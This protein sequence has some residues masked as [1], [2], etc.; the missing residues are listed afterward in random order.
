MR[1]SP[2]LIGLVT[3]FVSLSLT[4]YLTYQ[5]RVIALTREREELNYELHAVHD[6]FRTLLNHNTSIAYAIG[7]IYEKYGAPEDFYSLAAHLM[8]NSKFVDGIQLSKGG[9]MTHAYPY[10]ANKVVIGFD[11]F[12]DPL[13][14]KEAL[15]TI[16]RK[17]IHFAGPYD[18]L[19]GGGKAIIGRL[20]VFRNNHFIGFSVVLTKLST[21]NRYINT[22]D[23]G[24]SKFIY[25]LSKKHPIHNRIEYFYY[26]SGFMQQREWV[27]TFIKEGDWT[28]YVAH[29]DTY[30]S[31]LSGY[32][33]I[34]FLGLILSITFGGFAYQRARRPEILNAI[35]EEKSKQLV[36]DEQYYRTIIETSSDA[37]V[38]LNER[39]QV[40]YQTPSTQRISGYSLH[41]FQKLDGLELIHPDD[42]ELAKSF[43]GEALRTPGKPVHLKH[44]LRHKKGYY[45]WLEGTYRN[46]L[47]DEY[48]KRLVMTYTDVTQRVDFENR[49][50]K[51]NR[52][53]TLL[54]Q[55][56]D[57]IYRYTNEAELLNEICKCAVINGGYKLA[58]ISN[59][60]D[61]QDQH[62]LI[63]TIASYGE[64]DYLKKVVISTNDPVLKKGPT[65]QVLLHGKPVITN[66]VNHSDNFK[67]WLENARQF[68]IAASIVMP[69]KFNSD[70]ISG[71]LNIYSGSID[72]FDANEAETLE[73]VANNLSLAVRNIRNR[74]EK[75]EAQY[76]LKERIKELTAI[77]LVNK[78]IHDDH[79]SIDE[80]LQQVINIL[81]LGWQYPEVCQARI[82]YGE[83]V[84]ETKNYQTP[85]A[86]QRSNFR[87]RDDVDGSLEVSYTVDRPAFDEGPFL[88]EE[89]ELINNLAE[90][91]EDSFNKRFNQEA[92]LKSEANLQSVFDNT[93]IGYALL[94][95]DFIILAFNKRI[96]QGYAQETGIH[97][98]LQ[99][100]FLDLLIQERKENTQRM[101]EE[102]LLTQKPMEY[103]THF[104]KNNTTHYYHITLIPVINNGESI[105]ICLSAYDIT[106]AK[107]LEL[108]RKK[109]IQ[110]IIQR[111]RDLEQ[112][113]YI[114]A[115][116]V[117]APLATIL[118]LSSLLHMDLGEEDKITTIHGIAESAQRLDLVL[119]DL[120]Q[121][122]R[123][124]REVKELRLDVNLNSIL[125]EVVSSIQ[126]SL[127][128]TGAKI[129]SDF[130]AVNQLFTVRS[131]LHSIFL[132]LIT[133]SIKYAKP[134]EPAVIK[135][136][137]EKSEKQVRIY[138]SDNGIGINLNKYGDQLFGLYKR[139]NSSVEGKGLGLYMVK[140]QIEVLD[141][142]IDVQSEEGVGTTFIVTL[143]LKPAADGE[144]HQDQEI[145]AV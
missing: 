40:T 16:A 115:H 112:F 34:G 21:I 88:K 49:L 14:K 129:E 139:F 133:N 32:K 73:R 91:I 121:I 92:L 26:D 61:P 108:E 106:N 77:Y 79:L 114:V 20:P 96:E 2:L 128:Q 142:N 37:I 76:M 70:S 13:R 68:G 39:G 9:I 66:N 135:I 117:R 6:R 43:Y 25:Q 56:N 100:N 109:I 29:N 103:E 35:I 123:T 52:E 119:D 93:E 71:T 53:I 5:Q 99:H 127:N 59:F 4:Q 131:Y 116:N 78:V 138:F 28:I 104:T 94:N 126:F 118:G 86:L 120:N 85:V 33:I 27:S 62:Q 141:G 24:R 145:A 45:I 80:M 110:D 18:L 19:Q 57:T 17:E 15:Q 143:N 30:Q 111:N 137:S 84:F 74:E 7:S 132:N 101:F 64:T 124:R 51:I 102:I 69:L 11:L 38:L 98:Q 10:E 72:A 22:Q 67:P 105:G 65:A 41:E 1:N 63:K 82:R 75:E 87:T 107:N 58:W 130:T 55:V 81:P 3:F 46:L 42:R 122:L 97:L 144:M 95:R 140:T 36:T 90:M 12:K 47:K 134:D 83:K 54:N 8:E 113:A 23:S 48:V 31:S 50:S 44:R 89:R 60:P 136:R 125:R